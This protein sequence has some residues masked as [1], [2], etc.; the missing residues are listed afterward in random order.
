[1][2]TAV[3]RLDAF[4]KAD[5]RDLPPK[6]NPCGRGG[7]FFF[8]QGTAIDAYDREDARDIVTTE[9]AARHRGQALPGV[10]IDQS[11]IPAGCGWLSISARTGSFTMSRTPHQSALRF[12]AIATTAATT[13][14]ETASTEV[15]IGIGDHSQ[16][17][18]RIDHIEESWRVHAGQEVNHFGPDDQEQVYQYQN[19]EYLI[20]MDALHR[21]A[22]QSRKQRARSEV[23]H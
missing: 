9:A 12:I 15:A 14:E 8:R 13:R 7:P 4:E 5:A 10:E 3:G 2:D 21:A 11:T 20:R 17:Q 1:M 18:K 6:N 16:R 22:Q 19:R 23:N